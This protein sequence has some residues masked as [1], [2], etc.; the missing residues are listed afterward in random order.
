MYVD[1]APHAE[2]ALLRFGRPACSNHA[3]CCGAYTGTDRVGR[4][5]LAQQRGGRARGS[6][7]YLLGED[8]ETGS[9]SV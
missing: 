4:G 9:V 7:Q 6:D 8:H 3:Q 1:W 5:L 2:A